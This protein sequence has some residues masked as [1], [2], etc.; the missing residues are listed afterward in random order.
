MDPDKDVAR[1]SPTDY[2]NDQSGE[3]VRTNTAEALERKKQ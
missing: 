2:S 3:L 1:P